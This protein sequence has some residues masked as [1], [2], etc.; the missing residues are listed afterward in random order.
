MPGDPHVWHYKPIKGTTSNGENQVS[1]WHHMVCHSHNPP[2]VADDEVTQHTRNVGAILPVID[3]ARGAVPALRAEFGQYDLRDR[4]RHY[5][6]A[7]APDCLLQHQADGI[8][9]FLAYHAQCDLR[10]EDES[11]VETPLPTPEEA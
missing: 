6:I 3:K 5:I 9:K 2:I 8:A 10:L 11:G 7:V 1:N 4:L